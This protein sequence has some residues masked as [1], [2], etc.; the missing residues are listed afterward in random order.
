MGTF[1]KSSSILLDARLFALPELVYKT[2]TVSSCQKS[3][4]CKWEMQNKWHRGVF[5]IITVCRAIA[6]E[7]TFA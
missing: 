2:F 5:P 3:A 4:E 6:L 1:Y 7:V